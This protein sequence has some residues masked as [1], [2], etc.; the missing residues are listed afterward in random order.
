MIV[1]CLLYQMSLGS[2]H[3]QKSVSLI[4]LYCILLLHTK[5]VEQVGRADKLLS[6][7]LWKIDKS[8]RAYKYITIFL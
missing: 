4:A 6:A 3:S 8:H 7:L 1:L 2:V 5:L